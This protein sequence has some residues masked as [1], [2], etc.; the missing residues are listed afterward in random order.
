[1]KK[2]SYRVGLWLV[3]ALSINVCCAATFNLF[4]PA[5]G[6][7]KGSTST[8]ITTAAASSDIL[9]LFSGTCN[10]S[11]FLRGDGQCQ[12]PAG[13]GASPANPSASLGLT[14]INGSASTY[15]RS[16]A[17]PALNQAISPTWTGDHTFSNDIVGLSSLFLNQSTNDLSQGSI[18]SNADGGALAGILSGLRNDANN[19]VNL[20]ITSS[21]YSGSLGFSQFSGEMAV[22]YT[23]N[24]A[25][26]LS[27]QTN[28]VE[29]IAIAGDGSYI[30]LIGSEDVSIA[31]NS[32]SQSGLYVG[33]PNAGSDAS[34]GM[35][36]AN[37]GDSH[38]FQFLLPSTNHTGGSG[39]DEF[40]G[41]IGVIKVV[42]PLED[43]PIP[44][45]IQTDGEAIAIAGDRSFIDLKATEVRIN[46]V[47][48]GGGGTVT[49]VS[50]SMPGIFSVSGSPVTGSGTLTATASGTSGGIPYFSSSSALASSAALTNHAI[51]L[52]GGAGAAPTVV[53][54]LGTTTTLLHGNASG[55]PTFSAVSLAADVSGNLPVTNLN[56]GTSASSSTYWRGDGTWSTPAGACTTGS[57]TATL[58]GYASNPT[59]TVNYRVCNN[60]AWLWTTSAITGTSNANTMTMT[61]L[62]AAVQPANTKYFATSAAYNDG[63]ASAFS[64]I[65]VAGF[66]TTSTI[67]FND[68]VVNAN[69]KLGCANN[70]FGTSGSKGLFAGWMISYPLD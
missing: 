23:Q 14:A 45:S 20:A 40:T 15:M 13:G 27:I 43:D 6:L 58:T 59:G 60:V 26:P 2:L 33:N 49:S 5:T 11:T 47:P 64:Q 19:T 17:A 24:A 63:E 16:D 37:N 67:T 54:S 55:A 48:I 32:N 62:D 52:G 70:T 66:V 25:I 65:S 29:R 42:H 39:S 1:M 21:G 57:F 53:G 35:R 28:A 8:Y 3:V 12:T 22:L 18:F 7:L 69:S 51:V 9:S 50:L 34:A 56:S 46:G 31:T 30:Q 41:E 44:I 61:G 68:C 4:A 10:S 38:E 36:L